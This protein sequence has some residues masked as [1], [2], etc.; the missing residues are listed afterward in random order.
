MYA[1]L[2]VFTTLSLYINIWVLHLRETDTVPLLLPLTLSYLPFC[3]KSLSFPHP[4]Y[5][6]PSAIMWDTL[7]LSLPQLSLSLFFSFYIMID[8][9]FS[10]LYFLLFTDWLLDFSVLSLYISTFRITWFFFF[11]CDFMEM[12]YCF[13]IFFQFSLQFITSCCFLL[14]SSI[15]WFLFFFV[16]PWKNLLASLIDRPQA[17][18]CV[19]SQAVLS[20]IVLSWSCRL[21]SHFLCTI[22]TQT[23]SYILFFSF[24]LLDFMLKV[25]FWMQHILIM[26]FPPPNLPY[27]P[28]HP[29]PYHF[30]GYSMDH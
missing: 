25:D 15:P 26:V 19:F 28:T 9:L 8:A 18:K 16:F 2:Y 4:K 23:I 30:F 29:D 11:Q 13:K 21:T 6:L 5:S 3:P 12:F 27:F 10:I 22:S 20:F 24:F 14:E 17:H 1:H 7:P